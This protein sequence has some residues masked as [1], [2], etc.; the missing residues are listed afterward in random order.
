MI[1]LRKPQVLGALGALIFGG[2]AVQGIELDLSDT[3]TILSPPKCL[4]HA[5][6]NTIQFLRSSR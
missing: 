6:N 5:T 2:Q 1:I 3:G 4:K